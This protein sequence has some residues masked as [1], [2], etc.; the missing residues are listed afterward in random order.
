MTTGLKVEQG[1]VALG[2]V[3]LFYR[4]EGNFGPEVR[5]LVIIH[6]GPGLDH[7]YFLPYLEPI[8][9]TQPVIYFDQ[10]G[11]GRSSRLADPRGYT[12]AATL[13]DLEGLRRYWNFQQFDVLGFS[14]G[15]FVAIEYALRY[16]ASIRRLIL[17]DTA[18]GMYFAE[19][20]AALKAPRTTPE[21]KAAREALL[22]RQAEM[23][24][25]DFFK[26]DFRCQ[27]ALNYHTAPPKEVTDALVD[28]IR[29]G[30]EAAKKI[31]EQ[32]LTGWDS[33][34]Q[35]PQ[36]KLPT[37]VIAGEDDI[38]TPIGVSREMAQLIPGAKLVVLP[39]AGHLS[40]V[41]AQAEFNSAIIEFLAAP[42]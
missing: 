1:T 19:E 5:P 11:S 10:R 12:L 14:Y 40:F 23:T 4:R 18:P 42:D 27:V 20:A 38:V 39:E 35:L 26:E 36:I 15:G 21:M 31:R 2:E 41:E 7:T 22:A 30:S 24:A 34:P 8:A 25:D 13:E 28:N 29:Y 17:G 3:Q 33:R 16:P 9:A 6:G 37:L 32:S